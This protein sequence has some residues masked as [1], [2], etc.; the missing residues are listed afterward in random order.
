MGIVY[1]AFDSRLLR[2]VAIKVLLPEHDED[3]SWKQRLLHEARAA[4]GLN[5]PNIIGVYEIGESAEIDFIAMELVEGKP[6]DQIIPPG[7]LPHSQAVGIA[8]QI[9]EALAKAHACGVIHRDLKPRNIMVTGDRLVK[10]LDFGLAQRSMTE[11]AE[12]IPA[13]AGA[14]F[15]TPSYMSPEQARGEELDARTDLFSF[16]AVLYQMAT[17]VLPFQGAH[18]ASVAEAVLAGAPLR[19]EPRVA[20]G[21]RTYHFQS[22]GERSWGALSVRR[23]HTR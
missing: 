10:V 20:S 12:T 18:T 14:V 11:E 13:K 6:L 17:G 2:P 4:A 19:G 1:R 22:V 15:G 3:T 7:G 8:V 21:T 9:A 16:G 23:G 5:H